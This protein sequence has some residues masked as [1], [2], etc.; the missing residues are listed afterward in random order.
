MKYLL[1]PL[2][3][4]FKFHCMLIIAFLLIT[5]SQSPANAETNTYL[6]NPGDV[7]DISVWR[8][9]ELSKPAIVTP[10]GMISFP[11]AG[12]I[13]ASGKSTIEVANELSKRLSKYIPDLQLT[14]SIQALSG[15][16]IY[17]LGKVNRPGEYPVSRYVDVVQA[18]S[19]AGGTSTY[20]ALNK[21]KIL[22]RDENGKQR[23]IR[24]EYGDIEK[25]KNLEQNIILKAGD[26][27]VVP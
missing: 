15:N 6:L 10:D 8:E 16:R 27:V 1:L 12:T 18:L 20:A 4:N 11:L 17:I 23:A 2:A 22:R 21:I 3:T 5:I 14:V 19:I 25:G 7:I 13:E 9:E 26:T 24:F